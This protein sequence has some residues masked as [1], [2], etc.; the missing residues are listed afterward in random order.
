VLRKV[1]V[2][3]LLLGTVRPRGRPRRQRDAFIPLGYAYWWTLGLTLTGWLLAVVVAA[4]L[5]GIFNGTEPARH[6]LSHEQTPTE[7]GSISGICVKTVSSASEGLLKR[8]L[9]KRRR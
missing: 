7:G 5:T 4:G 6:R 3:L 9:Q 8:A 1:T 2:A